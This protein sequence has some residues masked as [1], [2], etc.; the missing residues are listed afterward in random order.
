MIVKPNPSK[1]TIK[2]TERSERGLVDQ[3]RYVFKELTT[4]HNFSHNRVD[5]N[6]SRWEIQTTTVTFDSQRKGRGKE[7]NFQML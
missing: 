5:A 7:L 1:I 2:N 3:N 4:N 6:I